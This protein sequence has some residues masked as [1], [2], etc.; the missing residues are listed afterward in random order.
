M[1]FNAVTN[2][3]PLAY[4]ERRQVVIAFLVTDQNVNAGTPEFGALASR[5]PLFPRED[6][7]DASPVHPIDE[8]NALGIAIGDKERIVNGSAAMSELLICVEKLP[9][10]VAMSR[11]DGDASR[12]WFFLSCFGFCVAV[13]EAEAVIAGL[14]DVAMMG[15]AVEQC[16]SHLGVQ[17][18]L[19]VRPGFPL[20]VMV[21]RDLIFR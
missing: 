5:G 15:K 17:P 7:T 19:T 18:T 13:L 10:L 14:D 21:N 11:G 3:V 8:A 1:A 16:R 2:D 12:G 6:D 20:D 4:V 9:G